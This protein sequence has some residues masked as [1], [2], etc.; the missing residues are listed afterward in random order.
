MNTFFLALFRPVKAF[1]EV[2]TAGKFSAMSLVVILFLILVNLILMMPVSEKILEIT[3]SSMSL[4]ENQLDM[5][6]Q[7]AHKMR[8]LQIAG[9]EI[10]YLI[11]FLFYALLLYLFVRIAKNKLTYKNA[12]QL[13]VYSYFIATIGDLVNTALLYVR[14]LDAIQ[15]MYDT[16]LIGLNLLTSV[17]QF[18]AT[19]YIFLSC[20]TPFQLMFVV[21]LGIGLKT[22]TEIKYVKA[23]TISVLLWLITIL[24]PTMSVYFSELTMANS[25]GM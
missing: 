1:S 12:L 24:I 6:R 9:S 23:L 25:G 15:N 8:Y 22:F 7:V 20:F 16:S 4:P 11:M 19:F 13:I 5:V 14:G 3:M 2:K 18:G 21:L 10:L 17:E